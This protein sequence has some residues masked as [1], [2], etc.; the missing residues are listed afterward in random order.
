MKTESRRR[1][2]RMFSSVINDYS[3]QTVRQHSDVRPTAKPRAKGGSIHFGIDLPLMLVIFMLVLF[4]LVMVYSAS[5]YYSFEWYR[6][7]QYDF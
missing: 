5:Y 1:P 7:Y 2:S 4:G 6:R 3:G